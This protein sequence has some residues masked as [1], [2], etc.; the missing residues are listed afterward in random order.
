M[1]IKATSDNKYAIKILKVLRL[2][3]SKNIMANQK[4]VDISTLVFI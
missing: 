2:Y 4:S 3:N 1:S